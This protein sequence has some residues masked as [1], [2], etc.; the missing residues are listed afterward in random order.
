[1][2]IK[3]EKIDGVTCRIGVRTKMP[4]TVTM[5]VDN[6]FIMD[7]VQLFEALERGETPEHGLIGMK[8]IAIYAG[9]ESES[10][11]GNAAVV[12]SGKPLELVV[13]EEGKDKDSGVVEED[14]K[15]GESLDDKPIGKHGPRKSG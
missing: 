13:E 10:E 3:S 1:M 11:P 8:L 6:V 2:N 14:L 5:A 9:E 15:D 12:P 7:A 4:S